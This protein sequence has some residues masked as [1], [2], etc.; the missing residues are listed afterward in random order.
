M[1]KE[2]EKTNIG[3]MIYYLGIDIK[4]GEDGIFV[5]QKMFAR[6]VLKKFKMEDCSR[7]NTIVE[8]GVKM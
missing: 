7:V 6:E 8:C 4:Q 2:F 1:I 3:L 5:N